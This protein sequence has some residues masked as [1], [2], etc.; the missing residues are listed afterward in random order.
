[1]FWFYDSFMGKNISNHYKQI[2]FVFDGN[3]K[4]AQQSIIEKSLS[5][6]ITHAKGT[7]NFY[8]HCKGATSISDL[9]VV[10]KNI[11]RDSYTDFI[12]DKFQKEN[13]VQVYTSGSTGTP[14]RVYQDDNK[15]K[16]NTADTLF[17][18][19][20]AGYT[21]GDKLYYIRHWDRYNKKRRLTA[22]LKNMVMYPVSA[23]SDEEIKKLIRDL[24]SETGSIGV[25]SYASGLERI[26]SYIDRFSP[27]KK[28]FNIKSI[29]SIAESLS[30]SSKEIISD[31]FE[32]QVICRYSNVENGIMSQQMIGKGDDYYINTA[33]YYVEILDVNEDKVVPHGSLGRIVITDLYNYAMPMLRYDTGD[34]GILEYVNDKPVLKK[35]EGRRADM[36]F[37]TSGEHISSYTVYHV[38]KYPHIEQ[39]Q[40][41][42]ETS[43][44]YVFKLKVAPGFCSENE[45]KREFSN[46]L[47]KDSRIRFEYV[48]EIPLLSSGKRK[49]VVNR[50]KTGLGNN[51]ITNHTES[52]PRPGVKLKH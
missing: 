52:R 36:I 35:V 1:M 50:S 16:R 10:N 24:E 14:F 49:F 44:E 17:F 33:S 19:E 47:G 15:K 28:R 5:D 2:R 4:E 29:L 12:S 26:A 45:I 42:Q 37:N 34:I 40:F 43:K 18:A 7:V 6:I 22:W 30:E 48:N 41:I 8:K 39:Y 25:I 32:T 20:K 27:P 9:K 51:N 11:I 21:V 23:L 38:L 3:D 31:Y 46:Y 13:L